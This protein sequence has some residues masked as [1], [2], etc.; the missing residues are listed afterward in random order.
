MRRLFATAVAAVGAVGAVCAVGLMTFGASA[1]SAAER[2]MPGAVCIYAGTTSG[3][4]R[5]C[6]YTYGAHGLNLFGDH[7]VSGDSTGSTV[8][9]LC[10]VS[11]GT[12]CTPPY[13]AGNYVIDLTP[14]RWLVTEPRT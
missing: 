9:Q 1:A 6:Y 11:P 13:G 3:S 5:T 14:Y 10:T 2:A 12:G 8:F 7:L 4:S